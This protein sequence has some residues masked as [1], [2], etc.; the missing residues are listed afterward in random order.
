V[1]YLLAL[2][3]ILLA[4]LA[5]KLQRSWSAPGAMY[6]LVWA[7]ACVPAIVVLPDFVS[8]LSIFVVLSFA[9]AAFA[10]AQAASVVS[11]APGSLPPRTGAA[12]PEFP[13]LPVI[14]LVLGVCGLAAAGFYVSYAGFAFADLFE[15]ETWLKLAVQN[16]VARY[17]GDTEPWFIR[18]LLAFDYAGALLAGVLL[19]RRGSAGI[20]TIAALP[21]VSALMMTAFTTA[22]TPML[23]A[24]IF[25]FSG[26][27]AMRVRVGRRA[28]SVAKRVRRSVLLVIGIAV[29]VGFFVGSLMLRY[30][31]D[32]ATPDLIVQRLVGYGF[33]QMTALSA[34]LSVENWDGAPRT[35]GAYTFAGAFE[36]LGIAQRDKGLYEPIG[37]NEWASESNVYSALRGAITDF[38]LP[39]SWMVMFAVSFAAQRCWLRMRTG[40]GGPISAVGLMAFYS[41]AA[42]SPV[43]SVFAYN[44]VLL[45]FAICILTMPLLWKGEAAPDVEPTVSGS[46]V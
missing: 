34:W 35:W 24:V 32:G 6:C 28:V 44:V 14:V 41:F 10:G 29:V 16:S 12:L 13:G 40:I 2:A 45:A 20:T 18:L 1:I 31:G 11:P 22:K 9:L 3:V 36:M 46:G 26:W 25:A 23:I 8:P 43:V 38:G 19:H 37:L 7:V 42:W 15:P 17:R 21:I 5:R 30:G 27:L 33:A 4:L 39:L